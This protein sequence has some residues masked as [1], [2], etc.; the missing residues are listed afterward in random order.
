MFLKVFVSTILPIILVQ[1]SCAPDTIVQTQNGP[2]EGELRDNYVAFEGIPYAEPPLGENRFEPPA[3][4][5]QLWTEPRPVKTIGAK[6]LQYDLFGQ[7]DEKI[8]GSEDCLFVNVY[9]PV[10]TREDPLP[11]ILH[12]HGGGFMFGDGSYY[13]P[14][15]LMKF[16]KFIYVS[17]N[18]RLGILGF[19]STKSKAMSGNMGM[20]DQVQALKWVQDNIEAFGGDKHN[21]TLTGFSAGGA[22]VHL[23][24]LSPLSKGLFHRGVSHSGDALTK[25][26]LTENADGKFAALAEKMQCSS[27]NLTQVVECL[28]SK[29]AREITALTP[30]FGETI[31]GTYI[32]PTAS[33]G[34]VVEE[35]HDGAFLAKTPA[36]YLKAGHVQ[37]LP[38]LVSAVQEEG[39]FMVAELYNQPEALRSV[40]EKWSH[41]APLVL[42]FNT[43][44]EA[45]KVKVSNELKSHFFKGEPISKQN[46]G[47]LAQ[48]R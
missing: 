26:V 16:G 3:P 14:G 6:C 5:G 42:D 48:V 38:W 20:K 34:L 40:D 12:I 24:Y 17:F 13:G 27:E 21:V 18:Y 28:K 2:V 8:V 36:E 32:H 19:L 46:F 4:L 23:H 31:G 37:K 7:S 41:V 15:H 9:K 47:K 1:V 43:T 22:A 39:V 10:T 44:D 33:F 30:S 35:D 29:P 25:F 45:T 11:V